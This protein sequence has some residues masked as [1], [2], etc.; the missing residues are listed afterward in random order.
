[1][2]G[3][4]TADSLVAAYFPIPLLRNSS[5]TL[6]ICVSVFRLNHSVHDIGQRMVNSEIPDGSPT[7]SVQKE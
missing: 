3:N 6:Y 4:T 1:M 5:E 2:Y 7:E